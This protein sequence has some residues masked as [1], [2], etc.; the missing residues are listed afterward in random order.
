MAAFASRPAQPP[1][2]DAHMGYGMEQF[3]HPRPV[4][5]RDGSLM[6]PTPQRELLLRGLTGLV[7]EL[8]AGDGVKLTCYPAQVQEITLIE[9]D[10][11][12]REI[13]RA[14]AADL[15]ITARI[16]AGTPAK[17]PVP[18]GVFDAVVC[19]LILCSAPHPQAVLAEVRRILRPGGQLRFYEHVRS[20]NPALAL[21]EALLTPL[22][23]R[24]A[25]GC[26]P[27]R[28]IPSAIQQAGFTLQRVHRFTFDHVSH[29]LGTAHPA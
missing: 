8:G 4:R 1:S 20:S 17:V 13:A 28:D 12:L 29:V 5:I 21:T 9:E 3:H 26:H 16:L 22:W 10:P 25:G 19:S 23:S 14:A 18:E 2:A 15:P 7:A 6:R 24:A 11:F 27:D